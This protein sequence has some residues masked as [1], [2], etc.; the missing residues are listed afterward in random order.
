M[1][2]I[3]TNI[4]KKSGYSK[5]KGLTFEV[6]E[7]LST[8]IALNIEGVTVDFTHHEV[9]IVDFNS[10]LQKAFDRYN[11][12]SSDYKDYRNMQ[13][14]AVTQGIKFKEPKYNCPA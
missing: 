10:E 1:L 9:M 13:K 8:L 2:A 11:W 14:Y 5:Y 12:D 6:K 3:I 7:V 4:N